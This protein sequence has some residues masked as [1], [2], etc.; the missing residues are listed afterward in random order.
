MFLKPNYIILLFS[1]AVILLTSCA[2]YNQQ[3]VVYYSHLQQGNYSKASEALN[4]NKLLKKSRNRLLYLMEKGKMEHLLGN[5]ENSNQFLNEA[6]QLMEGAGNSVK[7]IALGYL[8]NPMMETYQGEDFEKYMLHYYKAINYLQLGLPDEALVEAKRIT[9]SANARQDVVGNKN[10]YSRD[11]FSFTIQGLIYETNKDLN[12]AFIAYRNAAEVYLEND[13]R[14]YGVSMPVQLKKDVLR[15]AYLNGFQEELE[16]FEKLFDIKFD[17]TFIAKEGELVMFWENGLS[18]V[19]AEENLF[20]DLINDGR[21]NYYFSNSGRSLQVPF[22]AASNYKEDQLLLLTAL[23]IVLPKYEAQPLFFKK[24][25]ITTNQVQ[26]DFEEVQDI[27]ELAFATLKERWM[28]ELAKTLSRLAIKRL[29]ELAVSPEEKK[30]TDSKEEKKKKDKKE[31]WAAGLKIF[32]VLTEKADTRNWQSLP[33]LIAYTRIP[34]QPGKNEIILELTGANG[35]IQSSRI[36]L[37]NRGGI[38]I[39]NFCTVKP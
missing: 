26:A 11:A 25:R 17:N 8:I 33:N 35:N 4:E 31:M 23:R 39:R 3:S 27:N 21:G 29:A 34:L 6:D 37:Q 2:S 1:A 12:N 28:S 24:A 13:C 36:E 5:Y 20:F 22:S 9:L 16:R 32:N 14:F 7:D 38:Q 10:R 30:D 15:T 18:P 19:K